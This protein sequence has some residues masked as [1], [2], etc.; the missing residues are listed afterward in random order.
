M[1]VLKPGDR[2]GILGGGQLGRMLALKAAKLGLKTHIYSPDKYEAAFE[3]AT[4]HTRAAYEDEA[5]LQKFA[6]SVDVVTY[7]FEN[8]PA[9]TAS[10]LA[11]LKPVFPP[12]RALEISQDRLTEKEFIKSLGLPLPAFFAVDDVTDLQKAIA[13]AGVPCVLKTRRFG[14]DGK[15][16]AVIKNA[17]E[18]EAAFKNLSGAPSVMEAFIPLEKEISVIAVRGQNGETAVYDVAE[19]VHRDHILH[20]STVPA[21]ISAALELEAKAAALK[22]VG[23]LD[24]V[25]VLAVEFFVDKSGRLLVNEIA[26]RVHNSGHLTLDACLCCQFENHIRAVAGWPLGDTKR[27]SNA[28]MTNLIGD[29]VNNW[30]KALQDKANCLWLYGKSEAKPGRKMGHITRLSPLA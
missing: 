10:F 6:D 2:I 7:E 18:A 3:V 14:Y 20:T 24:Y 15:G 28:V 25:G 21:N 13:A 4:A 12:P 26:P 9:R 30:Q 11:S 1:S 5:Q 19:N 23:A 16:Q 17:D 27:T 22:L 29:E 8:V